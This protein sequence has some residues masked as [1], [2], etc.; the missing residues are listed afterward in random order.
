M[1]S[2]NNSSTSWKIAA[3]IVGMSYSIVLSGDERHWSFRRPERPELPTR[4]AND[5]NRNAIDSF[6]FSKLVERNLSVSPA[7]SKHRLIRRLT[8]DLTGIPPSYDEVSSFLNDSAPNGYERLVDRLLASPK[9]GERWAQH[10][11][12]VVRYAD[13][14]GFEYDDERPA[15]WRYRDWVIRSWNEDLPFDEFVRD[16]ICGDLLYPNEFNKHIPTGLHRLGPL[17]KNAGNQNEALNRQELLVEMTDAI[18]TSFLGLTIGCAKCHDHKFDAIS[19]ADYYSLQAFFAATNPSDINSQGKTVDATKAGDLD[20]IIMS[21]RE[22]RSIPE[23]FVLTRGVAGQH[24][25]RVT[26][27]L[28]SSL[29]IEPSGLP[30]SNRQALAEWLVSNRHPLTARVI[31]NRL[32]QYHF[33]QGIV[34]TP[35]DFGSMGAKPSHPKLL[36]W[37][38][39]ELMENDWSIKHIQRLM[40]TSSTY[41]QSSKYDKKSREADPKNRYLGRMSPRRLD[42]ETLRDTLL[43]ASGLLNE[44]RGG[45]GVRLVLSEDVASL[46]YKGTWEPTP[47]KAEQSRRTIYRFVKRNLRPT[48]MTSFDAPDTLVSC[49]QRSDSIHAGQALTMLNSPQT[50]QYAQALAQDAMRKLSNLDVPPKDKM[51]HYVSTVYQRILS[52]KPTT[53]ETKLAMEF[54]AQQLSLIRS[55][56]GDETN[57]TNNLRV[58]LTDLCLVLFNL[59]EFL[60]Y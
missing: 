35:N 1:K 9:Y 30:A 60:Y 19:Q 37:L 10:W 6:V 25:Q 36:D 45:P 28:P 39:I 49:S 11:L 12:D 52:R 40:V 51:R 43:S 4:S 31:V 23:T 3:L 56:G 59:D 7:E 13:S 41:R 58:A 15:A 26:A 53:Q 57:A 14:D 47:S 21:V 55:E 46:L 33:G 54:I 8:I 42:A 29:T 22:S 48:L 16:Q 27:E 38:A 34:S 32:W 20:D 50:N 18:G 5:W 17:R 24:E 2:A 44:K